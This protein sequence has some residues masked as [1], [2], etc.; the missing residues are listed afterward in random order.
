LSWFSP[1]LAH[2]R[3]VHFAAPFPASEPLL[4]RPA[5]AHRFH[6]AGHN[7]KATI[8]GDP[9]AIQRDVEAEAG[10]YA[11]ERKY[12]RAASVPLSRPHKSTDAGMGPHNFGSS[13]AKPRSRTWAKKGNSR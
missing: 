4:R 1:R 3:P 5:Q 11:G 12:G 13:E 10:T 7:F 6:T 9:L 2:G 8:V